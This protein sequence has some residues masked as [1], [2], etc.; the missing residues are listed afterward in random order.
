ML[1]HVPTFLCYHIHAD[2][3]C[4][5]SDTLRVP[6]QSVLFLFTTIHHPRH[7]LH[8]KGI[9]VFQ[10]TRCRGSSAPELE[11]A[12][13]RPFWAVQTILSTYKFRT[14]L[15]VLPTLVFTSCSNSPSSALSSQ[16]HCR[17]FLRVHSPFFLVA[18]RPRHTLAK[19]GLT[20]QNP[21]AVSSTTRRSTI[22]PPHPFDFQPFLHPSFP[23]ILPHC[24]QNLHQSSAH[25]RSTVIQPA[26]GWL[27]KPVILRLSDRTLILQL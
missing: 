6:T 5:C 24:H 15:Y 27:Q 25:V 3:T 14:L 11:T 21:T 20:P 26:R 12:I 9:L 22:R 18:G 17:S 19:P 16:K 2:P 1:R 10:C 8:V 7:L 13:F 4:N 23:T